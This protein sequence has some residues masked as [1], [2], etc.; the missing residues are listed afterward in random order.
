MTHFKQLNATM[1][2]ATARVPEG[3]TGT[4]VWWSTGGRAPGPGLQNHTGLFIPWFGLFF[5]F[6]DITSPCTLFN[7]DITDVTD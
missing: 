1:S 6:A 7:D 3:V 2:T 4:W 5:V